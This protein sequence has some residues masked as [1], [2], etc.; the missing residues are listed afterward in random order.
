[1]ILVINAL[2]IN[3]GK[4][5]HAQNVNSHAK[6]QVLQSHQVVQAV[7]VLLLGMEQTALLVILT[8]CVMDTEQI[9]MQTA[10][11]ATVKITG[12]QPP[13]VKLVL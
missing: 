2:V 1:M 5:L 10:T 3:T 13:I 4:E 6:T 9:K 8:I 11:P 12:I 7:T